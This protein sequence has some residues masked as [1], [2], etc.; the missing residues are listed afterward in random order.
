MISSFSK[1][2][3]LP[4]VL[5]TIGTSVTPFVS[6]KAHIGHVGEVAGHDHP[7]GIGLFAAS[8]VLAGWLATREDGKYT[9]DQDDADEAGAGDEVNA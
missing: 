5:V 9:A 2:S 3:L 7:V 4:N 6:A 8:S 1:K